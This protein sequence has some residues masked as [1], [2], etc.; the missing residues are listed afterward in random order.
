MKKLLEFG[1]LC[2][3][4]SSLVLTG[5]V[6]KAEA[7]LGWYGYYPYYWGGSV[8]YTYPSYVR[9][10]TYFP[11][12]YFS[13]YYYGGYVIDRTTITWSGWPFFNSFTPW[14]FTFWDPPID[15]LDDTINVAEII[16]AFDNN[17]A[18]TGSL[19]DLPSDLIVES[20]QLIGNETGTIYDMSVTSTTFGNLDSVLDLSLYPD[21]LSVLQSFGATDNLSLIVTEAT[22]VSVKDVVEQV[23]VPESSSAFPLIGLGVLGAGA[24]VKRHLKASKNTSKLSKKETTKFSQKEVSQV[25]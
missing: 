6:K 14:V 18:E 1:F 13:P 8:T 21:L 24:I 10:R 12:L 16:V 2:A 11:Y 23:Q 15:S 5:L 19:V 7:G 22:D 9:P 4:T 20:N 3:C 17:D 25:S